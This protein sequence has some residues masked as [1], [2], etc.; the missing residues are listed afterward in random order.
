MLLDLSI[1]KFLSSSVVLCYK[2]HWSISCLNERQYLYSTNCAALST[3]HVVK[4]S[5]HSKT[6]RKGQFTVEEINGER[7]Y[8]QLQSDRDLHAGNLSPKSLPLR[9]HGS[10]ESLG[11]KKK[12]NYPSIST[13]GN[14]GC[15]TSNFWDASVEK[16]GLGRGAEA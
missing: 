2:L 1:C 5:I 8:W 13:T 11:S 16:E 10:S 3:L 15:K 7:G 9:C 4:Y 12:K 6:L 14:L